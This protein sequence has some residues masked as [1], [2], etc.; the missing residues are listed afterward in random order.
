[1][2]VG[3]C[4]R[5]QRLVE[6]TRMQIDR[7]IEIICTLERRGLDPTVARNLLLRLEETLA[8][9][10]EIRDQ[11]RNIIWD[12]GRLHLTEVE[13]E[14]VG[15]VVALNDAAAIQINRSAPNH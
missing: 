13:S 7:Q 1:M 14:V 4:K 8:R 11:M 15:S 9:R 6:E 3:M 5:V 10:T 2:S 12:R